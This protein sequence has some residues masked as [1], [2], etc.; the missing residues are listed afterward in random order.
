MPKKT[1][2]QA[3]QRRRPART[4]Q[5]GVTPVAEGAVPQVAGAAAL[6]DGPEAAGSPASGPVTEPPVRAG[7][8]AVGRRRIGRV[9]PGT[10][11]GAR[12]RTPRPGLAAAQFEPLDPGD[13][14]IPFDRVPYVPSDLRRVA[15]IAAVMVVIII[16]AAVFVSHVVK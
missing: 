13:A 14:A 2:R 10:E 11:P 3:Q 7:T 4:P 6:D 8:V 15:V 16:V 5:A 9:G 12:A 1:K